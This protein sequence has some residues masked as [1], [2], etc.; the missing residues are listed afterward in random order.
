MRLRLFVGVDPGLCGGVA[1]INERGNLIS[2]HDTPTLMVNKSNGGHKNTY[3]ITQMVA[4]LEAM[5]DTG[6]IACAAIE[7]QASRPRQ[8]APATFSQG[9]GYGL[10]CGILG[11]L[12]IPYE[13]VQPK[14]WKAAMGIP[15]KS[16]K[17][18]SIIKALQ[19]FPHA[20]LTTQRGRDLDGRAEAILIA[21][22][23]RRKFVKQ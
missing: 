22:F 21:E 23:G 3:V 8:G 1:L 4:L 17:S 19:L 18:G 14:A 10:W 6:E 2:V 7:Y 16:D 11:S 12:R 15:L 9:Y 5:R 20:P 13:I